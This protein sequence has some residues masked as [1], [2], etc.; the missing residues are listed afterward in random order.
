MAH[1][2]KRAIVRARSQGRD[3]KIEIEVFDRF[4][5]VVEWQDWYTTDSRKNVKA[6]LPREV[7]ERFPDLES[8]AVFIDG[9]Q[10]I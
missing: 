6:S 10:L 7:R 3:W 9:V 4:G 8:M 5:R 1:G 2:G